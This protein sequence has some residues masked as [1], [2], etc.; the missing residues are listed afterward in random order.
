MR[1][2]RPASFSFLHSD[3]CASFSAGVPR[4]HPRCSCFLES[5]DLP[6]LIRIFPPQSKLAFTCDPSSPVLLVSP[7]KDNCEERELRVSAL[8][9]QVSLRVSSIDGIPVPA[10]SSPLQACEVRQPYARSSRGRQAAAAYSRGRLFEFTARLRVCIVCWR[11]SL[12]EQWCSLARACCRPSSFVPASVSP[13]PAAPGMAG[14]SMLFTLSKSSL[15]FR[16]SRLC[17]CSSPCRG[18]GRGGR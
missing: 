12:Q 1:L 13:L 11:A 10:P 18:G 3:L 7:E 14:A 9:E 16:S 4:P 5:P 6:N 8:C 17:L 15:A 2:R